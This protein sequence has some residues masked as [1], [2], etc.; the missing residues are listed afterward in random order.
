MGNIGYYGG[1]A[2]T[3]GTSVSQAMKGA[4]GAIRII[5]GANRAFPSTNV[6]LA[7]STDG[8]TTV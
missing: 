1:G 2:S 7:S 6:D 3:P 5:W 4:Q 8:E